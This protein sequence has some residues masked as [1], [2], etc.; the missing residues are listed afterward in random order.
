MF[1]ALVNESSNDDDP[2]LV[3]AFHH[4]LMSTTGTRD[5][6]QHALSSLVKIGHPT[7]VILVW[8]DPSKGH[9]TELPVGC[10]LADL[11]WSNVTA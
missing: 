10:K 8:G 11:Q 2:N 9:Y 3:L 1:K 4:Q 6:V 7:V 5:M